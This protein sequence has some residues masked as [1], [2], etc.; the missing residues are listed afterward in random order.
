MPLH[1]A[2]D[3]DAHVGHDVPQP[4][5]VVLASREQQVGIPRVELDLVDG[6]TVTDVMLNA[7]HGRGLEDPDHAAGASHGE[8]WQV[9]LF[10]V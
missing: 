8:E 7:G 9:R 2:K 1:A 10:F 4:K 5:R 6:V 3:G